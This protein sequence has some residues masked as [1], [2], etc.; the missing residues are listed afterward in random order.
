LYDGTFYENR[1][2][3][4]RNRDTGAATRVLAFL[5]W[6][7]AFLAWFSI[8]S[9]RWQSVAQAFEAWMSP[10]NFDSAG[11]QKRQLSDLTLST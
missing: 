7:D 2:V 6:R 4:G 5:P 8:T 9:A 1:V 10:D 3:R 11:K